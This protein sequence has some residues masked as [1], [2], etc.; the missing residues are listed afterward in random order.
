MYAMLTLDT[1]KREKNENLDALRKSGFVP[2]VYYGPKEEV[3]ML[4]LPVKEFTKVLGDA[5]E[6]TVVTLKTP[7]GEKDVLIH[8]VQ[9]HPVTGVP[10][11]I[12]F[13]VFDKTKKVEV[14]VPLEFFGVSPAVK[15]LGAIFSKVLHE[16][17]IEALPMNLPHEIKVDISVLAK[18]DDVISAGDIVL[19]EGVTLMEEKE[20]TVALVSEPREEI[21]EEVVAP[22][23]LSSIEV[24]KKG[25][26]DEEEAP[27]EEA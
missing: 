2:A 10:L 22:M 17:K 18:F 1:K 6:S 15:E 13:Y 27:A 7:D 14:S 12:D 25:K 16:L 5:G 9:F 21:I 23:D 11:H 3:V 4:S 8:D 26:K 20:E 19:P 24:E